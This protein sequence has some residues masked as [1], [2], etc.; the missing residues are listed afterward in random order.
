MEAMSTQKGAWRNFAG[1]GYVHCLD[2]G[3]V[4]WV[5]ASVKTHQIQHC[6]YG[7]LIVY[8]IFKKL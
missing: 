4:S 1:N 8:Y 2:F 7:Q 5:Y 6:K 3:D